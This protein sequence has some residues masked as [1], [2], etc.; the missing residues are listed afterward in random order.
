MDIFSME[1]LIKQMNINDMVNAIQV[2][3]LDFF[4]WSKLLDECYSP[5]KSGT[6]FDYHVFTYNKQP[7]E[8]T[9]KYQI[10]TYS[11]VETQCMIKGR[12]KEL[13]DAQHVYRKQQ[14]KDRVLE[15]LEKIGLRP[16][17][18]VE[19]WSK[20]GPLIED[21]VERNLLCPKPSDAIISQVKGDKAAKATSK[22]TAAVALIDNG[23]SSLCAATVYVPPSRPMKK[24]LV[25]ENKE[26]LANKGLSTAGKA[27][28]LKAR[29]KEW[30]DN[31]AVA[32]TLKAV[33]QDTMDENLIQASKV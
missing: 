20:W 30:V 17:K 26:W 12:N 11:K 22:R 29:V 8:P 3:Y 1:S 15:G 6:I 21:E 28:D 16:I 4:N 18:M 23:L 7:N 13:T 25:K 31:A 10:V 24:W 5:M 19:M 32:T 9:I 27:A 14:V 33:T 2:T